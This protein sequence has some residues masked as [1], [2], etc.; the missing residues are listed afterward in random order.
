MTI[1]LMPHQKKAVLEMKNGCIL[2]GG[3]GSGKT[4]TALSY[5]NDN[6]AVEERLIIITTAK[7]RDSGDWQAEA[8]ELALFPEVDSWNNLSE[9]EDVEGAFFI[10]DEQRVVGSGSW[11]SSFLK[12][13]KK[14]QWVLLSATPGDTWLDYVPVFIANGFYKN[15]TEFCREHVVF[16]RFAKFPK[17]ERFTGT[18]TLA[19]HLRSILVEM[20][21]EKHTTRKSIDVFVEYDRELFDLVWRRRWNFEKQ[22]PVKH[23]AEL[24]A[25][26]RKVAYTHPSRLVAVRDLLIQHPRMII[27]YNFDYELEILRTLAEEEEVWS[28]ETS[29]QQ[30][31]NTETGAN[32][33]SIMVTAE[34]RGYTSRIPETLGSFVVAEWNGHKHEPVPDGESW[35][36]LVQYNSGAE[37]WNCITTDTTIFYSLPYSYR[38]FEQAKGRTDRLN[39]PYDVINHYLFRGGSMIDLAVYKALQEKKNFNETAAMR[40]WA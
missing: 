40:A 14:N 36:Y 22:R 18:A 35:V 21:F 5:Y 2:K 24:F 37:G 29:N 38:M 34:E 19:R 12:V 17:V 16:S 8:R 1:D 20:P 13:T 33:G 28:Q 10:F 3:V 31:E 25:L 23:V 4:I 27:F 11:V 15:R 26:M 6:E 7:K 32:S 30:S 9:Y 39:T